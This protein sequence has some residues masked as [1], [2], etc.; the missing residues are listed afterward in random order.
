MFMQA[1]EQ[2]KEIDPGSLRPA[3]PKG[4]DPHL[5]F[6]VY[7]KG[8]HVVGM[9][10]PYRQFFSDVSQELQTAAQV[11]QPAG[12]DEGQEAAA[13]DDELAPSSD[14]QHPSAPHLLGLLCPSRNMQRGSE[15][16]KE[17]FT[18]HPGKTSPRELSLYHFLGVLMGVC[19]RTNTNLALNLPSFVWKQLVG[20]P[21]TAEDLAD[22]DDGIETELSELLRQA[23]PEDFEQYCSGKYFTAR[24]SDGAITELAE[25]GR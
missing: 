5:S 11:A 4:T 23:S 9:G 12:A 20:Q 18:L 7:F 10:G 17:N 3:Q 19:I 14:E 6:E 2:M 21:L 13:D 1:F 8:E 24:L 16:G 25:T 15:R 22:F